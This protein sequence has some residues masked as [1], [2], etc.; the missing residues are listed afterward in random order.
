MAFQFDPR[1]VS[2]DKMWG[3]TAWFEFPIYGRWDRP[4][5]SCL[6]RE[7]LEET[8]IPRITFT[9]EFIR[10]Q[11]NIKSAART[12]SRPQSWCIAPREKADA[13]SLRTS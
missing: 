11:R 1:K 13:L 10:K 7:P 6:H 9:R 2:Q 8:C 5:D 12:R 4:F 3:A